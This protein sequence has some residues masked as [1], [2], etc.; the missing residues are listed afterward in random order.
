MAKRKKKK[1]SS[2]EIKQPIKLSNIY[3]RCIYILYIYIYIFFFSLPK[4]GLAL[5]GFGTVVCNNCTL[6]FGRHTTTSK[7][8]FFFFG[9]GGGGNPQICNTFL[10]M[11]IME[12]K[13][14][15]ILGVLYLLYLLVILYYLRCLVCTIYIYIYISRIQVTCW[16]R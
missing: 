8:D 4:I 7:F 5:K 15:F 1:F 12:I 6:K 2:I 13:C 16:L 11:Y 10:K 3:T 14:E 9:G